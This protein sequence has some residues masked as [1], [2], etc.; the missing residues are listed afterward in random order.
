MQTCKNCFT[1]VDD[2]AKTCAK[3]G[4]VRRRDYRVLIS[5]P[6]FILAGLSLH[7]DS[8]FWSVM[9]AAVGVY[10][11]STLRNYRWVVPVKPQ[12]SKNSEA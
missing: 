2:K 8:I 9:I 5:G 4:A 7:Q 6:L 10:L 1:T 12:V 11:L 3:C